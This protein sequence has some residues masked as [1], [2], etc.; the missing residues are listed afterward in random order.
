MK[1]LII[2]YQYVMSGRILP[3]LQL[4]HLLHSA[5]KGI[6]SIS[7]A[8]QHFVHRVQLVDDEGNFRSLSLQHLWAGLLP[9]VLF[10]NWSHM[11]WLQQRVSIGQSSAPEPSSSGISHTGMGLDVMDIFSCSCCIFGCFSAWIMDTRMMVSHINK[12]RVII[13][14]KWI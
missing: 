3:S 5:G 7:C 4:A 9:T 2:I 10:D 14:E 6:R 1:T 13:F 11:S 8:V 12:Y